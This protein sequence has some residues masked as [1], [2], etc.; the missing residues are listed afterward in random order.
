MMSIILV[1]ALGIAAVNVVGEMIA[2]FHGNGEQEVQDWFNIHVAHGYGHQMADN[3]LRQTVS[4]RSADT[5]SLTLA[6]VG[7][8]MNAVTRIDAKTNWIN[9]ELGGNDWHEWYYNFRTWHSSSN[10]C[11]VDYS[12]EDWR[13]EHCR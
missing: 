3:I 13:F 6:A 2:D 10:Q 11:E 12:N 9:D 1:T 8:E 7:K 5:Q 4:M